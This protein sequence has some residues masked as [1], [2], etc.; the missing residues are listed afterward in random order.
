M[1]LSCLCSCC[2]GQ[3]GD[4]NL[5]PTGCDS[6]SCLVMFLEQPASIH[7][8]N[9]PILELANNIYAQNYLDI[10][11]DFIVSQSHSPEFTDL[12]VYMPLCMHNGHCL[13]LGTVGT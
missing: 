10:L 2:N 6:L 7:I 8:A 11:K 4:I 1:H 9:V 3:E 5:P 12:R 13:S